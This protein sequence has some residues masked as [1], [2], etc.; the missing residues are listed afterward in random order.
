[1][2][3]IVA[4]H[5]GR[6]G[7]FYNPGHTTFIGEK[8]ISDFTGD[9]FLNY[10]NQLD[11]YTKIKDLPNLL[12][13]YYKST[14]NYYPEKNE[15]ALKFEKRTGLD[16]GELIWTD[17]NGSSVGLTYEQSQLGVGSIDQDGDYDRTCSMY[18]KDC[19][20][21]DLELILS[22]DEWNKEKLLR[23]YF[24]FHEYDLSDFDGDWGNFIEENL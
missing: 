18:L 13:L 11:I 8:K 21:G 20:K 7:R 6:G 16:F 12:E 14:E 19:E 4:F 2:N 24:E 22:S 15:S 10:E 23:D 5:T 1:M 17:C 3:T 9:L